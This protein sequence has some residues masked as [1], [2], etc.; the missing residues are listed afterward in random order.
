MAFRGY[1]LTLSGVPQRLSDVY[2]D[3]LGVVNAAHD[4]PYRQLLLQSGDATHIIYIGTDNLVSASHYA[5]HLDAVTA[6]TIVHPPLPLGPFE[7]GP[8]K[9]SDFWVVG[10]AND[11]LAI[12]GVPF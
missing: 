12:S 3:G 11:V 8:L 5:V 6:N 2:Q 1:L 10:T 4:V 7:S 9:L